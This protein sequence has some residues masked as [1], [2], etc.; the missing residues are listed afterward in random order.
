MHRLTIILAAGG[1]VAACGRTPP[2][3]NKTETPPPAAAPASQVGQTGESPIVD[4]RGDPIGTAHLTEGP[5]G[6][7]IRLKFQPRAL[8]PGWHGL[9]V[10]ERGQ[11]CDDG[12]SGFQGAGAHLGHAKGKH[13]LLN[14]NGPE[15]GD[16]PSIYVPASGAFEVEVYSPSLTLGQG[17]GRTVIWDAD[18]ASLIIHANRDDQ[19]TQPIGGAGDRVACA[20]FTAG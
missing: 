6:L 10:H 18:G 13:G 12:A 3:D 9:H 4:T 20:V 14:P 19:Q 1:G 7:L 16:L 17:P 2:A 15:P 5:Y 8:S 11:G